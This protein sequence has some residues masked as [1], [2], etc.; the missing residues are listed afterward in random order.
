MKKI[1]SVII[2]VLMFFAFVSCNRQNNDSSASM[3]KA[4][5][6][7]Q[8][9]MQSSVDESKVTAEE[10]V[11]EFWKQQKVLSNK[12]IELLEGLKAEESVTEDIR[13]QLYEINKGLAKLRITTSRTI[14]NE[15]YD[16]L[17][18]YIE[19]PENSWCNWQYYSESDEYYYPLKS[20]YGT[21]VMF[22]EGYYIKALWADNIN[23]DENNDNYEVMRIYNVVD[24][25]R[26][27]FMLVQ[28]VESRMK[29]IQI[30]PND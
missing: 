23:I 20:G 7:P 19:T 30:H 4:T 9:T 14:S 17:K 3:M 8:V 29:L 27:G 6:Q 11:E 5:E 22:G 10:E 18:W 2:T 21:E 1:T 28:G 13:E 15:A 25:S 12:A 16:Q 26:D 24:T